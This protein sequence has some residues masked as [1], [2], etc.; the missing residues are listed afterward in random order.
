MEREKETADAQLQA[1]SSAGW[2]F[3]HHQ[4]Q[5]QNDA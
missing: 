4:G 5:Q 3:Q 1:G 2:Q